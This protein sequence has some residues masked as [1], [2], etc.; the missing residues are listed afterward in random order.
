M[1][2]R[3]KRRAGL[4]TYTSIY[5]EGQFMQQKKGF[6]VDV[7]FVMTTSL[8]NFVHFDCRSRQK[9]VSFGLTGWLLERLHRTEGS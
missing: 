8:Q 5:Q 6:K 2:V 3:L 7:V 9:L 4:K 1:A